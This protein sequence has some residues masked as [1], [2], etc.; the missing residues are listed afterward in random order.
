MASIQQSINQALYST[1]IGAGLYAHS[2]EGQ[3]QAKIRALSDRIKSI[4]KKALIEGE[5]DI[6]S[7]AYE[8]MGELEE[9]KLEISPKQKYFDKAVYYY[10]Q[11]VTAGERMRQRI[12]ERKNEQDIIKTTKEILKGEKD[13]G[14]NNE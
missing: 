4:E 9:Q 8:K 6:S 14:N 5:G 11:Q 3:K 10:E 2:P 12:Q 1:Q 7:K 13:N